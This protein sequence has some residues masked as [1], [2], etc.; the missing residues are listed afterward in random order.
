MILVGCNN[1]DY[2]VIDNVIYLNEVFENGLVKVIVDFENVIIIILIVCV[3]QF[4]IENV[5][6]VLMVDFFIFKEYNEVNEILYEVFFEQYF[7]YDKEIKIVVGDVSVIFS[8]FRVKFYLNENGEL[9]VILVFFIEIQGL[10]F[11]IG[12]LLKFIILLDKLLIQFVLFMNM[13]NVVKFVKDELWGV[14]I[15]EWLF[16][17]WVQMDG[18]DINNQ[19]I[20]NL[21]SSDYE[22]YICFGDVMIFYN[23]LQ[24]KI[25]G[26]Q[27]NMVILFEKNKWYYLVFVYNFFGLLL[28]Y[29]NG[30]FDV[31][32]QIK[33]G[34][35]RFD[36]MNMVLSGSYFCNNCQMVQVCFW[37]SVISQM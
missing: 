12:F 25:F 27:V 32:L 23:L 16:E 1:V 31:I 9:Y 3:G 15:N 36:K 37:K 22:V 35:V 14:I 8:E 2:Q 26:S 20:F 11:I 21:G 7:I 29:I 10:V 6:V 33:G 4:V 24:V 19:V 13:I 34:L 5:I 17:V 28:I 18:F 30:V